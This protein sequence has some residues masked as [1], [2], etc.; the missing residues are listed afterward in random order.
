MKKIYKN[1][2]KL[3]LFAT[4]LTVILTSCSKEDLILSED[5]QNAAFGISSAVMDASVTTKAATTLSSGSIGVY[6]SDNAGSGYVAQLSEFTYTTSWGTITPIY[7]NNNA[8]QICAYYPFAYVSGTVDPS[9]I[10]IIAQKQ[11]DAKELVYAVN[12]NYSNTNKTATFAMVQA[13]SK[14]TFT[15][16]KDVS[17]TGTGAITSLSLSNAALIQSNTINITNGTYGTG[18]VATATYNPAIASLTT[19]TPTLTALLLPPTITGTDMTGNVNLSITI[20][21]TELSVPITA[22]SFTGKF[23]A[24]NNYQVALVIKGT[25]LVVSSVTIAG[26]N[27]T[28][29]TGTWYPAN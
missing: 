25:S 6:R 28:P 14:I 1:I 4:A 5:T 9:A 12:A 20:D 21:G 17:Y 24:G 15:I 13:Y 16:N 10:S 19:G 2:N 3:F 22:S 23:I 29:V 18:T 7:L 26:W 27:D 8:A 11:D